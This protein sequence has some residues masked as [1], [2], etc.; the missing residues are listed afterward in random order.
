M[1]GESVSPSCFPNITVLKGVEDMPLLLQTGE[2][3]PGMTLA[4][5][6]VNNFQI[7]L[8]KGHRLNANDAK[9]L[10]RK[11]PDLSVC[12]HDPVLED[13]VDFEEPFGREKINER[14]VRQFQSNFESVSRKAHLML[15]ECVAL[16]P[17]QFQELEQ[18]ISR[19]LKYIRENPVT[20][21]L[22]EQASGWHEY[23]QQHGMAVFNFSLLLCYR[24]Q[25]HVHP[26]APSVGNY[27]SDH[28]LDG[29]ASLA[30]AALF[31]DIGMVP[32]QHLYDKTGLLT[33][34]EIASI[35]AHPLVGVELL[36]EEINNMTCQAIT[37]HHE[38]YDGS[39]YVDGLKESQI[40]VFARILRIVD[41]YTA[42]V[43]NKGYKKSK[44]PARAL[45]EMMHGSF[46]P[47]YDPALLNLFAGVIQPLPVG[48]KLKLQNGL[49]AVVVRS[50]THN[51][52]K[53]QV[54]I[55]F[56]DQE[57]PL[58][59]SQLAQPFYLD[60]RDDV[61][62]VSFGKQDISFLNRTVDDISLD[63]HDHALREIYDQMC[64]LA[65]V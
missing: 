28:N 22:L 10:A 45:Y 9:Y 60:E 18:I 2:L 44:T 8:P 56:D 42:A 65:M 62:A 34:Q 40:N 19:M 26:P 58:P 16:D 3:R 20:M 24:L 41:A 27:N 7:L 64:Q 46:C 5:D 29:L 33:Q 38:N 30:T 51:P 1:V 21:N 31:H 12:V 61:E 49:Y 39:G 36:P 25:D 57:K 59:K 48:A 50:N 47:C 63:E 54:I 13:A 23:L 14:V 15:R 32:I 52:F 17:R 4:N 43:T 35:K 11:Y 37:Q 55:A 6:I 53:P